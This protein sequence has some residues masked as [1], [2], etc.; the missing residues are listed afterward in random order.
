MLS[1]VK[2]KGTDTSFVVGNVLL[3][4]VLGTFGIVISA[5]AFTIT[6]C[7][8]PLPAV[9]AETNVNCGFGEVVYQ[10]SS[11]ST[12]CCLVKL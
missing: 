5:V 11:P 1:K 8:I 10:A 9:V 3:S 7:V 2:V 6:P 4:P 12:T